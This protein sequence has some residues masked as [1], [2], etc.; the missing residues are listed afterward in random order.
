MIFIVEGIDGTGKTTLANRLAESFAMTIKHRSNPKNEEERQAMYQSYKD[1]IN[2]HH[3]VI[4]D[5]AFYSEMVYGP[6]KRDQSYISIEQM[7]EYEE[8][9]YRVGA[10]IIYCTCDPHLAYAVAM[11]RGEQYIKSESEFMLLHQAYEDLMRPTLH[12]IPVLKYNIVD[13]L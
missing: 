5:R 9:L 8:M 6:I 3:N 7:H 4:W 1:D 10:L 13:E 2:A 12:K 11:K